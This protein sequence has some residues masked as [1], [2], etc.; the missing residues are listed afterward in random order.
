MIRAHRALEATHNN[1]TTGELPRAFCFVVTSTLGRYQA[2]IRI[3]FP[4][5]QRFKPGKRLLIP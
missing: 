5:A 4:H 3:A 2:I 1:E